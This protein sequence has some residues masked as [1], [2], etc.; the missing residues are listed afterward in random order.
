[1]PEIGSRAEC[2]VQMGVIRA[3]DP[4]MTHSA[5]F[6]GQR[7]V[8]ELLNPV[9]DKLRDFIIENRKTADLEV[10]EPGIFAGQSVAVCGAGPS[11]RDETIRGASQIWACN[12][13]LPYLIA[14][15]ARVDAGVGIDQT[16][17]ML[18]EWADPPDVTYYVASTVDPYLVAHLK[19]HNRR[20]VFFHN[21]VGCDTD[22]DVENATEWDLYNNTWPSMALV[23]EGF[24]VVS[25]TIGLAQWM[26]FERVDV[27]GADCA[28]SPDGDIAHANGESSHEAYGE[29]IKVMEATLA[30]RQWRTRPDML[31]DAVHL[32]RRTQQGL[33]R[34][35]LIGDTLPVFFLGK[36][37]EYLDLACRRLAPGELPPPQDS[38]DASIAALVA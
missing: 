17:G 1:M 18:R 31:M 11:L 26:G 12:S 34:I 30:G 35:R 25:R 14:N 38:I 13:A 6:S 22:K 9:Q 3:P 20:V 8:I 7:M 32:A 37:P 10:V 16:A 21:H 29:H 28:F 15:G 24:T 4:E 5:P 36:S 2:A 27:Y 23:G 19:S 33:G